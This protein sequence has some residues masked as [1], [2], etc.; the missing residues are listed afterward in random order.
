[1]RIFIILVPSKVFFI[2]LTKKNIGVSS[3]SEKNSEKNIDEVDKTPLGGNDDDFE[4]KSANSSGVDSQNDIA[5]NLSMQLEGEY[6]SKNYKYLELSILQST[7]NEFDVIIKHQTH[8][9]L[10]YM[11]SKII[12]CKGVAFVAYQHLSIADP[13]IYIRTDGKRDVKDILKEAI[14]YARTEWK[15]MKNAIEAT[16]L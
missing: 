8:G 4:F 9:F 10:N 14:K 15:G 3:L 13:K 11:V 1:M 7:D 2:C 5:E 12:Q 16:K 6:E